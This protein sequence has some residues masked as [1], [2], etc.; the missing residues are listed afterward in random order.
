MK[1]VESE[2]VSLSDP[3]PS[4]LIKT[5]VTRNT[6]MLDETVPAYLRRKIEQILIYIVVLFLGTAI[7]TLL[8]RKRLKCVF[9]TS[10]Y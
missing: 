7:K 8:S 5:Q 1:A 9:I 4:V 6:K 3:L 10:K 2:G